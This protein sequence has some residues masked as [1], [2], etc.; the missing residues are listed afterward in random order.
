[1]IEVYLFDWGDTLMVNH[2]NMPGKMCD[3]PQVDAI[4]GARETLAELSKTASIYVATSAIDSCEVEVQQ[5]FAR[6]GLSQYIT[7]YFCKAN[8]GAIKTDPDFLD[9]ILTRLGKPA[10]KVAMVG[11]SIIKDIQPALVAGILP[12]W[13]TDDSQEIAGVRKIANL[14]QLLLTNTVKDEVK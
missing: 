5:A 11:D 3:W 7:G 10:A 8:I 13:L 1:M 14:Q 12:I 6:V 2:P 4:S 9:L